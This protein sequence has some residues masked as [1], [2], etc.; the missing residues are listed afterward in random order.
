[1]WETIIINPMVNSMLFL[2]SLLFNNLTLTIVVFTVLIR[3]LTFPLT[4]QQQKSTKA[5]QDLQQGDE[6]K[7]IQAKYSAPADRDKLAQEQMKL[8]QQAGVNPFGSC[9]PLLIQFPVIIGMYQAITNSI[10]ATPLQ[11]L[12]LSTHLYAFL[13]NVTSLIPLDNRFL[14]MNLGLPDPFYIMP[15]LVAATTWVQSKVMTPMAGDAQAAQMSQTMAMTSTLMFGYFSLT[16]ASG[17]SIYFIV[18]N[19]MSIIQYSFSNPIKW[20]NIFSLSAP[21]PA[22]AAEKPRKKK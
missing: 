6:W 14:W 5:L 4:W 21:K 3:A 8:Y 1:M 19:L 15:L 18:S 9:L 17:L 11:L 12:T 20:R 16:F 10:A 7:K 22:P 13:P 2:Y